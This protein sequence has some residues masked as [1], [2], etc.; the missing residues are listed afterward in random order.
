MEVADAMTEGAQLEQKLADIINCPGCRSLLNDAKLLPCSHSYCLKCLEG[1]TGEQG[2]GEA[3]QLSCPECMSNFAIPT[4]GL[5]YLPQNVYVDALVQLK[6]LTASDRYGNGDERSPSGG[7]GLAG[8]AEKDPRTMLLPPYSAE[9]SAEG[10]SPRSPAP[11]LNEGDGEAGEA[12]TESQ[13]GPEM[14]LFPPSPEGFSPRSPAPEP[15][16]GDGA[17]SESEKDPPETRLF[18]P[19]AE[20][21][22]LRSLASEPNE[23]DGERGETA[24]TSKQ[25]HPQTKWLD[26]YS[27][28]T[29]EGCNRRSATEPGDAD[30]QA[31]EAA[32]A[33]EK[34]PETR[35]FDPYLA[36][37]SPGGCSPRSP[38]PEP[39]DG[40]G[41]AFE[42]APASK[43]DSGIR[44]LDR[45]LTETLLVGDSPH[46]AT[47]CAAAAVDSLPLTGRGKP[48]TTSTVAV[49]DTGPGR[50]CDDH[51]DRELTAYCRDCERPM[52]ETCFIRHHN[53][54]RHA[55]VVDVTAEL[56][57][58]LRLDVERINFASASDKAN[59]RALEEWRCTVWANMQVSDI[60]I[61][62]VRSVVVRASD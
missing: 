4:G 23:C 20:G 6:E 47:D 26:L 5:Q 48:I 17:A 8:D 45:S 36:G 12:A 1:L 31:F 55:H 14:R 58:Q 13:K 46:W 50:W 30:G 41:V 33:S 32:S 60:Y 42:A 54:H 27:A 59:L 49:A 29:A 44:S 51:P 25:Q 21:F 38:S 15:N 53:G 22:S 18:P 52:C 10:C 19:S 11:E 56:K 37:T 28:E 16:E 40:D 43:N 34:D 7:D 24:L 35:S 61:H 9:T 3:G 39:N 62:T 57:E 2:V